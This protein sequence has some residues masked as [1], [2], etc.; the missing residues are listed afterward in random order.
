VLIP[1]DLQAAAS[2]LSFPAQRV[3]RHL[4]ELAEERGRHPRRIRVNNGPEILA[5][6]LQQYCSEYSIELAYIQ[7]GKPTQ[8]AYI[9]RLNQHFR[10]D[11]LYAYLFESYQQFNVVAERF[12][13]DFNYHHPHAGNGGLP[14]RDF[15]QRRRAQTD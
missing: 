9:E 13:Q 8:N 6:A 15:G 7:P 5:R 11:V 4:E 1:S 14:P 2:C 3:I 10:E 12:R